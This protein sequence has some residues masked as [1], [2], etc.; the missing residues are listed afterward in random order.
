MKITEKILNK[1]RHQKTVEFSKDDLKRFF[2]QA[3][4]KLSKDLKISGFRP[5]KAPKNI[6]RDNIKEESLREEAYSLSVR[7]AW[8]DIVKSLKATP[9][10]DPEVNVLAFEEGNEGK[11]VFEYDVRPEVKVGKWEKI[12]IDGVKPTIIKDQEIEHVLKN[13]SKGHAKKVMTLEKAKKGNQLD[14]D[15]SGTIGGI[16]KDK[17]TSKHFPVI[18]GESQLVSGFEKHLF[19]LKKGDETKFKVTFPEDYFDVE[20]KGKEVEFTVNIEEVYVIEQPELDNKF[21]EKFGHKKLDQMRKAIREDLENRN[22]EEFDNR[23]KAKWLAEF[24]KLITTDVPQSLSQSEVARSESRWR[25]FLKK[26]NLEESDWLARQK[27]T[28]EQLRR[29]WGKAASTSVKIG[30]GLSQLAHE[31][32]R[33]LK[34]NDDFQDYLDELIKKTSK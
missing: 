34:G 8:L 22:V 23:K 12:K 30:L 7:D 18:L 26:N 3:L 10:Q 31:Q 5:G 15:F 13:L 6:A 32:G 19:G 9:I 29:D 33:E 21:A 14:I 28:L 17:L 24:E 20:M 27:T 2:D 25:E 11:I 16:T 4:K 1:T